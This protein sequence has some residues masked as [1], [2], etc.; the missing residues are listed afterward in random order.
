MLSVS[1]KIKYKIYVWLTWNHTYNLL[2]LKIEV[3]KSNIKSELLTTSQLAVFQ[4][5]LSV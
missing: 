1:V 5:E 2:A 4:W 3:D